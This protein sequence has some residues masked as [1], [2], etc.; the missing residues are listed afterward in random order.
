MNKQLEPRVYKTKVSLKDIPNQSNYRV[1]YLE[2]FVKEQSQI[3]GQL[4][5][6]FEKVSSLLRNTNSQ[7]TNQYINLLKRMD[8]QEARS[9]QF[10]SKL[11][12]QETQ[13]SLINQRL[14]ELDSIHQTLAKDIEQDELI[15]QAIMDQLTTQDQ[16]LNKLTKKIEEYEAIYQE[17][18]IQQKM[19][20]ELYNDIVQKLQL[21]DAFHQT[22]LEELGKQE[23]VTQ[24]LSSQIENVK[25]II[26][27]KVTSI[28]D[29]IEST[30]KSTSNYLF[31]FFGKPAPKQLEKETDEKE[32]IK[33]NQ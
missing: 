9:P 17:I 3:N 20:T 14:Q 33:V 5:N 26:L 4:S 25:E 7:Q 15:N 30:Y 24:K 16:T 29:K 1:N 32:E 31:S 12:S 27:E 22:I 21:Q 11:S 28:I 19:Q 6:S 18:S 23:A 2:E 10:L 8:K 13:L